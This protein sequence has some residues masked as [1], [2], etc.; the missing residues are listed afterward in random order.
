MNGGTVEPMGAREEAK[1]GFVLGSGFHPS[2]LI[3]VARTVEACGFSSI[4]STEDYFATGGVAGA[5]TILAATRRVTVGT[6]LLSVFARH[7]ALTAMEAATLASAHPGRF[8]LGVGSGGLGWLDQQGIPHARPLS[9]VRAAVAAIRSLLDGDEVTGEHGG[10]VFD[11]VALE[12]PPERPPPIWIGATGPKMT[13]LTGEIA[14]GLLLSVFTSPEFVRVEREILAASPPPS[15]GAGTPISTFAFFVLDNDAASARAK[16][17]PVL[18]SYLADGEGSAMT[19]AIGITVELRALADEGG[20]ARLA[21]DMPDA[22]IDR[23]AVCGD[24]GTCV[25]RIHALHEAGSQE[26][27]LAPLFI[28]SLRGDIA[29]LGAALAAG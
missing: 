5:A 28:D 13:A 24:L 11:G 23:L 26:V 16:I 2:Q 19:D 12:F 3:D 1:V 17:R 20:A 10:F 25:E 7:P 29:Q 18:A 15:A 21:A 14:D 27:A 8:R 4:W 22:W 6:G 9:A